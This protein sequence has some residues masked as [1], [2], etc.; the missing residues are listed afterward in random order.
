MSRINSRG[1]RRK[2]VVFEKEN[3]VLVGNVSWLPFEDLG[4]FARIALPPFLEE[5]CES[6][7]GWL[8]FSHGRLEHLPS[9]LSGYCIRRMTRLGRCK[10]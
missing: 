9:K 5:E 2:R 8:V 7:R 10:L 3:V 6:A 1:C 4:R